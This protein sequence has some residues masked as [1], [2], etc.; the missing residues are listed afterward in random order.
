MILKREVSSKSQGNSLF[1]LNRNLSSPQE[2]IGRDCG[3]LWLAPSPPDC[4]TIQA[5]SL[6]S[7]QGGGD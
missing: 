7:Q 1:E 5:D 6:V 4:L 2:G 3:S